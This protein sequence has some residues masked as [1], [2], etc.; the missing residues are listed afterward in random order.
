M[1]IQNALKSFC[2]YSL[3]SRPKHFDKFS[4]KTGTGLGIG[5]GIRTNR[6]FGKLALSEIYPFPREAM[7]LLNIHISSGKKRD[8]VDWLS[9]GVFGKKISGYQADWLSGYGT[10]THSS[11][12]PWS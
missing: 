2:P 10:Q 1:T 6:A 3:S 9:G 5:V 12:A 7:I 4:F 8:Q 11:G